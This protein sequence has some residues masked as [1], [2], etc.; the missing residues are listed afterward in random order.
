MFCR[1]GTW[2]CNLLFGSSQTCFGIQTLLAIK[3][4]VNNDTQQGAAQ[5]VPPTDIMMSPDA[6]HVDG[7][8]SQSERIPRCIL[9]LLPAATTWAS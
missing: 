9:V 5:N 7:A 2:G 3:K 1:P 8:N 4:K 6:K